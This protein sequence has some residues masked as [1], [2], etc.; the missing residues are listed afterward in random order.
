[1]MFPKAWT[2]VVYQM[3]NVALSDTYMMGLASPVYCLLVQIWA[4]IV[5][6]YLPSSLWSSIIVISTVLSSILICH[7]LF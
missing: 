3:G 7:I 6:R 4:S 2:V 1:M 5:L